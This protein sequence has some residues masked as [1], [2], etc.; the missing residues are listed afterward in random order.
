MTYATREN[1]FDLGLRAEAFLARPRAIEAVDPATGVLTLRSNGLFAGYV[2]TLFVEG[3]ATPGRP[4]ASLPGGLSASV[5]YEAAPVNGSSDLFKVKPVGGALISSF[6][7][8]GTG[9]FSMVVDIG[10]TIDRIA[11]NESGNIDEE[12]TN[13]SPPITADPVTHL[14]PEILIGVCA[15]RTAV[16]AALIFGLSSPVYQASLDKLIAGQAFDDLALKRWYEGRYINVHPPDQGAEPINAPLAGY[17][18]APTNWHT[19]TL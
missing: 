16:R 4:S 2:L 11:L 9:V 8:A 18:Y 7:N 15:R 12:L 10:R 13:N 5:V 19:G 1:V 17:A 3:S 6:T 14:Y